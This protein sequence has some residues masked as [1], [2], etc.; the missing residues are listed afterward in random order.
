MYI[1]VPSEK[2]LEITNSTS[3][4]HLVNLIIIWIPGAILKK[5]AISNLPKLD[6][7]GCNTLTI[8]AIEPGALHDLPNL[9]NIDFRYNRI[10]RV[11]KGVFNG[12][13][14]TS[15]RLEVNEIHKIDAEAFSDMPNLRALSLT[16]NR[17]KRIDPEWFRSLPYLD[18]VGLSWN[19]IRELPRGAFKNLLGSRVRDV[20]TVHLSY[21]NIKEIQNGAFENWKN[22]GDILLDHNSIEV[23]PDAFGELLRG[24]YI[25]LSYNLLP[26]VSKNKKELSKFGS[27]CLDRNFIRHIKV[28]KRTLSLSCV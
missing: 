13:P 2:L 20:L 1:K 12:L 18:F 27:V 19:S 28:L 21:N 16:H 7:L 22:L 6:F 17:L 26:D 10:Q 25:D 8:D 9:K 3:L 15:L 11:R 4:Q 23:L 14:I 5:N 24:S